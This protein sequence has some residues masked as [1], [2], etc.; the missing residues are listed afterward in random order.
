MTVDHTQTIKKSTWVN[1]APMTVDHTQT[2][3]TSTW[4]NIAPMIVDHT[5][6]I[7]KPTWVNIVHTTNTTLVGSIWTTFGFFQSCGSEEDCERFLISN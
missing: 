3:K 1:I 7:K 4:V 5:Q 6:T 2:I